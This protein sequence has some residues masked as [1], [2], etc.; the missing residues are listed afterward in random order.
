MKKIFPK[1]NQL[2]Y[3]EE[4]MEPIDENFENL[5]KDENILRAVFGFG[6]EKPSYP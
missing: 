5:L 4:K 6:Y 2:V 1:Y 3:M